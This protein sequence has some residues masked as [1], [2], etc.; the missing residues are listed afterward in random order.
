MAQL[1]GVASPPGAPPGAPPAAAPT[2]HSAAAPTAYDR[3][4]QP[5]QPGPATPRSRHR[6]RFGPGWPLVAMLVGWPLWWVLGLGE[7]VPLLVALVMVVQLSRRPEVHLPRGFGWWLLFLAWVVLGVTMLWVDAP[8]AVP[9]GGASRLVIFGFRLSWYVACTVFVVW[10][11]TMPRRE[12][13]DRLVHACVA[14]MFAVSTVGGLV[15][16][17]MPTLELRTPFEMVLPAG[18]RSN[19]FVQSLVHVQVADLQAVLGS[20][21]ARPKAP[22]AYTNTWGSV[23]ALS[24]V[25]VGAWLAGKRGL[26]RVR[27]DLVALLVLVAAVP[28]ILYSLNRGLW[29]SLALGA[30]GLAVLAAT[31]GRPALLAGFLGLGSLAAVVVLATPLGALVGD[32]LDHQHSNDRR[33]EL[34]VLTTESVTEGSP[35]LGFGSTRDVQGSFASIAGAATPDCPGCGVPPLGTQGQ[36]WTVLFSQGWPGLVFFVSF[37]V[38]ALARSARCRSINEA[39]CTFVGAFFLLQLPIYDTL[40]LPMVI[41]MIAIGLVAREQREQSGRGLPRALTTGRRLTQEL[42]RGIAAILVGTIVGAAL[43]LTVA[44]LAAT[45]R[46][47]SRVFMA[48]TPAPVYLD[49]EVDQEE[50]A[51]LARETETKE[52]TVDTEAALLMSETTLESAAVVVDTTPSK[53][54]EGL[55]VTAEPNSSVL[56]LHLTWPDVDEIPALVPAI[57]EAYFQARRDYLDQRREDLVAKLREQL[58][59]LEDTSAS[60]SGTRVRLLG[61]IT[62]L[63]RDRGEVGEVVRQSPPTSAPRGFEVPTM[64]GAALGL[65]VGAVLTTL[66]PPRPRRKR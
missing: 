29:G 8:G 6:D 19:G 26:S 20:T 66:V 64:S 31:K 51:E 40:G 44:V 41:L 36:L 3:P 56:V 16:L 55:A 43:G 46:H 22:F 59:T 35:V 30:L 48:I 15:A 58:R 13:P 2:G 61:A 53:L 65:L 54:R 14:W 25:F 39:V 28:P 63:G 4:G 42:R 32:R 1:G 62:D 17:A 52:I 23:M 5:G 12:V 45:P 50:D 24:L 10:I 34:L 9:G 38:L 37:V 27:G 49:A 33:G 60:A 18:L 57:T 11:T 47:V 7:A 21:G